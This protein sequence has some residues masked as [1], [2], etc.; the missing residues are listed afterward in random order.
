MGQHRSGSAGATGLIDEDSGGGF[1][2]RIGR[3]LGLDKLGVGSGSSGALGVEAGGYLGDGIYLNVDPGAT[4]GQPRV[5][6]EVE[7]TPRLKVYQGFT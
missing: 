7:L 6:V 3:S 2:S 4:T 5:G 1:L